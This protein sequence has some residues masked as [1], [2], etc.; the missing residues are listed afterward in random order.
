MIDLPTTLRKRHD[1][2]SSETYISFDVSSGQDPASFTCQT[3]VRASTPLE[4]ASQMLHNDRADRQADGR[5]TFTDTGRKTERERKREK[6]KV[7]VAAK[8]DT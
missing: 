3:A 5:V 4:H 7:C 6:K 1:S 8:N 2:D